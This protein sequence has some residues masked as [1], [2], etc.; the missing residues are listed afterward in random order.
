VIKNEPLPT[1]TG[2][3]RVFCPPKSR[4]LSG[5]GVGAGDLQSSYPV[6]G[7]WEAAFSG[8]PGALV[9]TYVVCL[10]DKVGTP[11]NR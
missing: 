8:S 9:G 2:V 10:S 3:V 11:Q 6:S 1:G 5:G 4:V 7:G